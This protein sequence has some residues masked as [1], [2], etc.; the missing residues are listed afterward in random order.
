MQPT[1]YNQL[2]AQY[3]SEP[4]HILVY[5]RILYFA[6]K[7]FYFCCSYVSLC[8]FN[9]PLWFFVILSFTAEWSYGQSVQFSSAAQSCPTLRASPI[10]N[11]PPT[12]TEA[13]EKERKSG[14][15]PKLTSL[16]SWRIFLKCNLT[17]SQARVN[18]LWQG[19]GL[20]L[21]S[22]AALP[23]RDAS[24]WLQNPKWGWQDWVSTNKK[25][26]HFPKSVA[27]PQ[28]GLGEVAQIRRRLHGWK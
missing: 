16:H 26:T 10:Y 7:S 24:A 4:T 11:H 9:V 12:P 15:I 22:F 3:C 2:F 6:I 25:Q 19:T 14:F 1:K 20:R 18:F 13:W 27:L 23:P 8:P 21:A 17:V 5:L 28:P